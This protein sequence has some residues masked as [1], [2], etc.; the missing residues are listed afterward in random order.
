WGHQANDAGELD[1]LPFEQ[2]LVDTLRAFAGTRDGEE[3]V[4]LMK[5]FQKTYTGNVY[6]VGLTVYPGALIVNKRF[7]NIPEG[8]PIFMFNWAEDSIMRERV[9]VP[10]GEQRDLELFPDSLPSPEGPVRAD[11]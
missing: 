9:Y 1:L 7:A 3:R 10:E 8:A 11:G 4:E 5:G 6:T 2:E